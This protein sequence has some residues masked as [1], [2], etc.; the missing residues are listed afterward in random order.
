M[1]KRNV[2]VD[3]DGEG[4]VGKMEI[5]HQALEVK[6]Q[7]NEDTYLVPCVDWDKVEGDL[8][9]SLK[10]TWYRIFNF[11]ID[12]NGLAFLFFALGVTIHYYL[13]P[14]GLVLYVI[15]LCAKKINQITTVNILKFMRHEK[16]KFRKVV[17]DIADR[18]D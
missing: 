13:L 4:K 5:S 3:S 15:G 2:V 14:I 17:N 10:K 8:E 1:S 11:L 6:S 9:D 18:N 12:W 7:G 16:K